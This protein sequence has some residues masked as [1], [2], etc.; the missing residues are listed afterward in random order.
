MGSTG[1]PLQAGRVKFDGWSVASVQGSLLPTV[2]EGRLPAS[3]TEIV[4]GTRTLQDLHAHLGDTI[5]VAVR[6]LTRP[7]PMR[8][9]GR[10][11]LAPISDLEQLGRGAV[12]AP[13]VITTLAPL[14]PPGF[15]PPPPGDAFV[16]F[17][18][19]VSVPVAIA[20][21]Q[22]RLGATSQ[23]RV[24]PH[25]EP[26]DVV[27]FGQVRNLPQIL[28]GLLGVVAAAAL[29]YL[30]VSAIRRRRRDLAVLKT[31]GFVPR[32]VSAAVAWQ[33]TTVV[34]VAAVPALPL[35][36]AAGRWAWATVA[37]QA[38][39]VVQPAVPWWLVLGL[40]PAAVLIANVVA[41]G[42]AVVAGRISPAAA[43]RTE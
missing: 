22:D 31:L 40:V 43:L 1:L 8:I 18:R 11:V 27:N 10:G 17:R 23:F 13:D 29:A 14:A 19:G 28:A 5:D 20:D 36:L 6:D 7:L 24:S 25:T 42:P 34:V 32:Q 35:G 41:A 15:E 2:V 9:V 3:P 30:L 16:R 33:A 38:G 21:L 4:L 39:L 26:T 37:G 12:L